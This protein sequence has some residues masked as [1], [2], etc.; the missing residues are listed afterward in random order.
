MKQIIIIALLLLLYKSV[1]SQYQFVGGCNTEGSPTLK[2]VSLLD[3][4]DIN[5]EPIKY[6]R[7]NLVFLHKNDGTGGFLAN[8]TA[9]MTYIND[10]INN[11]NQ[12]LSNIPS[13]YD[14][15]CYN[16]TLGTWSDS[17]IRF[18]YN[19]MFINNTDAWKESPSAITALNNTIVQNNPAPAITV[20]YVE[21]R[22]LYESI[23]DNQNCTAVFQ[24]V[25]SASYPSPTNFTQDAIV[26]MRLDFTKYYWM[27]NCV[28]GNSNY[29]SPDF[30]TVYGWLGAGWGEEHE[31][32]HWLNLFD[33]DKDNCDC[34]QHL[35]MHNHDTCGC[36]YFLSPTDIK[37]MH[38]TLSTHSTRKYVVETTYSTTPISINQSATW[39]ENLRIYR[40]LNISNG[41]SFQLTNELIIPSETDILV[42]GNNT[43]L[44]M[45]GANIHTPHTN[46]TLDL[47]VQQNASVTVNNNTTIQNCNVSVQSGTFT[48]NNSN[49]DISNTGSFT[50][51]TGAQFTMNQGCIY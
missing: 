36:G 12:Y 47:I 31:L 6:I 39:S 38:T 14:P 3:F 35:M 48:I 10:K 41:A 27:M 11:S 33:I 30:N 9:H 19:V 50:V 13:S 8:N 26:R 32:L 34:Y 4:S 25:S 16:G 43:S 45:S 20:F 28:L 18:I 2:S 40:G 37:T 44:T 49:I 21:K 7:V 15:I 5:A 23:V 22:S 51:A 24:Q 46:S 42:S 17:R 29:G 1:W